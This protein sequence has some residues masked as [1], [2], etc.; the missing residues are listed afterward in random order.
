MRS[1]ARHHPD[2]PLDVTYFFRDAHVPSSPRDRLAVLSDGEAGLRAYG[3]VRAAQTLREWCLCNVR[4]ERKTKV[5]SS[6]TGVS[7]HS[8]TRARP[9]ESCPRE[10]SPR[11]KTRPFGN[12]TSVVFPPACT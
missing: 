10:L 12:T 7:F 4:V 3:R 5:T 1:T 8:G 6:S 2:V 9:Q 11:P